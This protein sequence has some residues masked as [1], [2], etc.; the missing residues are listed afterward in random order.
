MS[1]T[2]RIITDADRAAA[3]ELTRQWVE[4]KKKNPGITQEKAGSRIGFS[5][6]VFSQYLLCTIPLGTDA[7]I[8]FAKLFNIAPSDIR[9]DIDPLASTTPSRHQLSE[10]QR[11]YQNIPDEAIEIAR[12]WLALP[13]ARRSAI[14]DQIFIEAAVAHHIPWLR[15]GA[16]TANTYAEFEKK[17]GAS[18]KKTTAKHVSKV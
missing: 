16:P 14:R 5:Q 18:A 9:S 10:P 7:I 17:L 1:K 11:T 15:I 3:R 12:A 13:A 8:K 4:Y 2:K 6:A